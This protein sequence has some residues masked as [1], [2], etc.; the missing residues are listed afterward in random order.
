MTSQ[1]AKVIHRTYQTRGY[2]SSTGYGRIRDVLG[3]CQRLYNRELAE[4]KAVYKLTKKS[5]GLYS[6]MKRLTHLRRDNRELSEIDAQVT[7]GALARL[8]RAYRGFFLR[9]EEHKAT[10]ARRRREGKRPRKDGAIPGF[11][12]FKPWQRYQ[13]IE[14]AEV[15][16]GMVKNNRIKIKGL[17]TIKI[18]L[19]Q[20]LPDIACLKSLRMTM[21]GRKLVVDLVYEVRESPL[22][23]NDSMVGID[24]GVNNRL[25][26]ATGEAV[27]RRMVD[28]RKQK[29][30][31]RAITRKVRG[32][33]SRRKAVVKYAS[34]CRRNVVR[35]RNGCHEIT[36]DIV[37][38][39]GAI[40]V[41]KLEIRN[42]IR[43]GGSH[44]R[45]LNR[46]IAGQDVGTSVKPVAVQ[47][48]MR[49]A[50]TGRG[51]PTLHVSHLLC[52]WRKTT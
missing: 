47:G 21:H 22:S 26:F 34:E 13:C 20:L 49:R 6:R 1:A 50:A 5:T 39:F 19:S 3:V 14:L 44:K 17:P 24:L 46:E 7:R 48:R 2:T 38:R 51:R 27:D 12:R 45:G 16:P 15:R 28:R 11:P 36:A 37:K 9:L 52:V 29:R 31:Q 4:S 35:N 23:A 25:T 10:A 8:N 32:S 33:K 43:A 41:E 18:R 30:L 42:M 40:A